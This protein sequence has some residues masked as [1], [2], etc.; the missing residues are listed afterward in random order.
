MRLLTCALSLLTATTFAFGA[1]QGCASDAANTGSSN[2]GGSGANNTG[3]A[4]AVGGSGGGQNCAA[5]ELCNG[6]DDNCDGQVDEG[7]SCIDGDTQSC[8]S[9][10]PLLEGIGACA[11]GTQTCNEQGVFGACEDEVLPTDEVCDGA[12]NNCDDSVD[13]GFGQVTCGLGTCQV[14]V[15]E[16]VNN[17]PIVCVPGTPNAVELCDGLDD[18][19]DGTIDNGCSC[20]NGLTQSC[21]GGPMGTQGVG[22]CV[23]GTQLCAGGQWQACTGDVV[24]GIETCDGADE[25]CNNVVDDN[26]PGGGLNCA[27]QAFGICAAGTTLCTNGGIQCTPGV[28]L[29]SELCNLVDDDCNNLTDEN[30]PEGGAACAAAAPGICANGTETC[31][32]GMIQCAA[33]QPLPAEICNGA[34]DDCDNSID[35]GDPGGGGACVAMANGICATGTESCTGGMLVCDPGTPLANEICNNNLD[36]DCNGLVDDTCS[37]CMGITQ[38]CDGMNGNGCECVG[39][40]CC[41]TACQ[42]QHSNGVGQ[43]FYDCQPLNTFDATQALQACAANT[44]NAALCTDFGN[45]CDT[46]ADA[47]NTPD[48]SI[49]CSTGA[50]D[51]TCWSYSGLAPGFAY[52]DAGAA[53]CFCVLPG[54]PTWN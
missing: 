45:V 19:C 7:C 33:G 23:A 21:Y 39:T 24:P 43:N 9:G 17:V 31:I 36:D 4:V 14:T 29:Q 2:D 5:T 40:G 27:A 8:W 34:D 22:I 47:L 16:C 46:D 44:G 20:Q 15:E 52:N 51:C 50:A 25:D 6:L 28:A 30:N 41:N 1:T 3:G 49:V 53:T 32:N 38:D 35:E 13:E 37:N 42:T 11:A 48:T 12:D 54:D 18:D 26:N 10:D